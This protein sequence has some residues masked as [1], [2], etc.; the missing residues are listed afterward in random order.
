MI[1]TIQ[2]QVHPIVSVLDPPPHP[3]PLWLCPETAPTPR[4]PHAAVAEKPCKDKLQPWPYTKTEHSCVTHK[5]RRRR[6]PQNQAV[7]RISSAV[8]S[9]HVRR[10]RAITARGSRYRYV[11]AASMQG[12]L[13]RSD[14]YDMTECASTGG[15]SVRRSAW[16]ISRSFLS[17]AHSK[18]SR[19]FSFASCSMR[20][21]A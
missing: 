1:H 17:S 6:R 10:P 18:S 12:P 5:Y 21:S 15:C 11:H 3:T 19:S 14:P 16:S 7:L 4:H 13:I 2:P 9:A 8:A 20:S